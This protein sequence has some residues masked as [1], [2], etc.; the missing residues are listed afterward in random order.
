MI[1][2]EYVLTIQNQRYI[3]HVDVTKFVTLP[4]E[5]NLVWDDHVRRM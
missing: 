5:N 2:T 3:H 1:N 4:V